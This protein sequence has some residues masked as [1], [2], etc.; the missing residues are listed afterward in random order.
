MGLSGA[1]RTGTYIPNPA[2]TAAAGTLAS[3]YAQNAPRTQAV[4]DQLTGQIPGVTANLPATNAG[5]GAAA[6]YYGD[7]LGGKYLSAGNPYLSGM[8][9]STA[10]DVTDRLNSTFGAAGRTGSDAH[11]FGL[12]KGLAEAENGLRYADYE[13]ERGRMDGA[14]AGA[15]NLNAQ[16]IASALGLSTTALG[17]PL[18]QANAY[19]GGIG[20]LGLGGTKTE[21]SSQ[22]LGGVLAGL[23]GTG[24]AG[25]GVGGFR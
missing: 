13:A 8:I 25:W 20:S 14:A 10:G 22:G 5:V 4:S 6:G 11:S 19:A 23:A 1:K 7:V 2:Q 3:V 16:T 17:L 21:T 24:L 18:S 12:A 15:G 9:D